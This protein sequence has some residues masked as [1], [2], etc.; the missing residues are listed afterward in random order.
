MRRAAGSVLRLGQDCRQVPIARGPA[1]VG[2]ELLLPECGHRRPRRL[3]L[4]EDA[5]GRQRGEA[6]LSR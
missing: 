6:R 4:G 1:V 3:P 5:Q 2:G